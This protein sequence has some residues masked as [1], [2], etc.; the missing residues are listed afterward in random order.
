MEKICTSTILFHP[1]FSYRIIK[2][3][4]NA[5]EL[6]IKNYTQINIIKYCFRK[7][8]NK[9]GNTISLNDFAIFWINNNAVKFSLYWNIFKKLHMNYNVISNLLELHYKLKQQ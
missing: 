9:N 6:K 1:P 7:Y 5:T 8:A 4:N 3:L 2:E